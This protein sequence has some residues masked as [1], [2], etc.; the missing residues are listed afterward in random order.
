MGKNFIDLGSAILDRCN[1]KYYDKV[2]SEYGLGYSQYAFLSAIY[3]NEGL[4]MNEL[5]AN[6]SYDKG[7]ITK[8]IAKL[9]EMDF[10]R[11]ENSEE[12]KR[13]KKLY[14]TKK[15]KDLMPKLY[16]IRQ[17]W[18]N[19]LT[20]DLTD[21]EI[22][23]Y[24]KVMDKLLIKAK[25]YSSTNLV[26]EDVHIYG[27]Q[28]LTLLD[29]PGKMAA[30][31]FTGGCNFRCPFCHNKQLVFLNQNEDEIPAS[32]V[33]DYLDNRKKLLDGVCVT[34]GEPLLQEG[35]ENFLREIRKTG[36]KIKLDTNGSNFEKL[37]RIIE[38]GLVDYVAMDIKNEKDK[39]SATIGLENFSIKNVEASIAYLKEG[40]VDY[41]FR[42]TVVKEFHEGTDFKKVGE[43][44]KGAKHYYLQNF[45]DHGTCIQ[46][47]LHA[48]ERE[49]LFRIKET[50][51]PYV[52][53]TQIRGIDEEDNK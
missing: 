21:E 7:S 12:D 18:V 16:L 53:E 9:E 32:E 14:T 24:S 11:I 42:T 22:E 34:G 17:E 36:L 5:A 2:L 51:I 43:W 19:Y 10:V 35:I 25:E 30:T 46:Q 13:A 40:H 39:Y 3:E 45:E 37:K 38:E 23:N 44:L 28:K 31:I 4:V 48:L 33:L 26:S 49:Q 52:K 15:A 29:Y 41:E 6:G 47:G 8:A 50:L 1:Q 27:L 20:S